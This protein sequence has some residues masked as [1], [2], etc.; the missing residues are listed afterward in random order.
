LGHWKGSGWEWFEAGMGPV[1]GLWGASG[2]QLWLAAIGVWRFDGA[3][4]EELE[5]TSGSTLVGQHIWGRSGSDVYAV[6]DFGEARRWN[7][8]R[9]ERI[10]LPAFEHLHTVLGI[11][12]QTLI[13]GERGARFRKPPR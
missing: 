10:A 11:G 3:Q 4:L 13:M 2:A 5:D 9:L 6:G 12:E 1:R 8:A 7:G